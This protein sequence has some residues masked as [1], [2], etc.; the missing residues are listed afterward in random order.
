MATEDLNCGIMTCN[1]GDGKTG[2]MAMNE[3]VAAYF[4]ETERAQMLV[5]MKEILPFKEYEAYEKDSLNRA[6]MQ[7]PQHMT[8]GTAEAL[9]ARGVKMSAFKVIETEAGFLAVRRQFV[10]DDP[11]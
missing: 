5:T 1:C 10:R 7:L 11:L 2:S 8:A 4:N 9:L 3:V 6:G